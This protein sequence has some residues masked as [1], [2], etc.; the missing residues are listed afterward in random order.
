MESLAASRWRTGLATGFLV[1]LALWPGGS[2]A[3]QP[4]SVTDVFPLSLERSIALSAR[5]RADANADQAYPRE[6]F[7]DFRFTQTEDH[8]WEGAAIGAVLGAVGLTLIGL[9]VCY[10]DCGMKAV[11]L[12]VGGGV[13]G[14]FV[15][16]LIGGAIPKEARPSSDPEP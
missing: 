11:G 10:D 14:G 2:L 7:V 4:A 8:R 3:A 12:A 13:L 16:L 9:Q 5:L 1:L 15:G 6:N